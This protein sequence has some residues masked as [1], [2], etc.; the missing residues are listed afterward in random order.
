MGRCGIGLVWG[1]SRGDVAMRSG[2]GVCFNSSFSF[3]MTL[4][5]GDGLCDACTRRYC[6]M[7]LSRMRAMYRC[8]CSLQERRH[9]GRKDMGQE[10]CVCFDPVINENVLNVPAFW[11][12][13]R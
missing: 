4:G 3:E 1:L 5:R 10:R 9:R 2:I 13:L 7:V 8:R 12:I 6:G 11:A